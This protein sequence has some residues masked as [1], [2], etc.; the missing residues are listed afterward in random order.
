[1]NRS[2]TNF[3]YCAGAAHAELSR[4]AACEGMVLLENKDS[5]L[6]LKHGEKIAIFGKGAV[7]YVKGGG[8]SG[9]VYCS[10]VKNIYAGL[11]EKQREGKVLINR[12]VSDF[13]KNYIINEVIRGKEVIGTRV[14]GK[15]ANTVC[16][17][18]ICDELVKNAASESQTAIIVISRYSLEGSDR[19][20]EGDYYLSEAE[21]QLIDM[22]S[23]HFK[24][25]VLILNV[26]AVVDSSYFAQ[27]D[28]ISA[29]L[30]SWQSGLEGGAAVADI[31]C[32][33]T[34][35]SGRLCDT[36]AKSIY[37]YPS[38]EHLFDSPDYVDYSEDIYVGYRYFETI[39]GA[40]EKV[41]YPFGYGLSYTDFK[42]SNIHIALSKEEISVSLTVTNIGDFSGKEVVGIYYSAPQ[43][44]LKK[45]MRELCAFCK[46]RE[47]K[48][49]ESQDVLLKF[50]ISDMA[51]FDDLGKIEKSA[52]ILEKGMYEFYLGIN[53]RTAQKLDFTYSLDG[54]IIVQKLSSKCPPVNLKKRLISDGSYELLPQGELSYNYKNAEKST[55]KAPQKTLTWDDIKD[56]SELDSFLAQFTDRELCEFLGGSDNIGVTNTSCFSDMPRLNVPPMTTADGPAGLRLDYRHGITTTAWPCASQL[57]C[58][59]NT[60]LL[61][62]IGRAAARELLENGIFVWLAPA[63][64]IH[65]TPLCGR[66]FEYFSEDPFL[67]GKLAAAEVCGIQSEGA[68]PSIK[69]FACN[70]HETNRLNC[71]SRV[72]ERALREIYLKGFEICVKEANPLTLMSSYNV[73]NGIHASESFDLLTGILRDEWG[74]DGMITSDWGIKNNPVREVRAGNDMKMHIGYPEDLYLALT[75][76][77]IT[78]GDLE[79]CALRILK[80]Y[81][82]LFKNKKAEH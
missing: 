80:V 7:A 81:L 50:K 47:L 70:N 39:K 18:F 68:A 33:D 35:P 27:S 62:Q 43:G 11:E 14:I 76:G 30:L 56:Q 67:T 41:N 42:F 64:N 78:R 37:D 61:E 36:F 52:Y 1:M 2:K 23:T 48:P 71:D 4:R 38:T 6:P 17:P 9:D 19:K 34:T 40:S 44:L 32:G 8:G 21:R 66:N 22:V 72:S 13:Y 15:D 12:T 55:V 57:A 65:R 25:V 59:F 16:E 24:K 73:L 74:F 77:E 10:Y 3:K 31:L 46:T 20:I 28:K 26:G 53:V 51:S 79:A 60:E 5:A 45:P 49:S 82:R 29:V 75:E 58:S 54:D 63:L 69:H